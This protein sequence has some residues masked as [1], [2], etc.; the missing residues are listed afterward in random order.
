MAHAYSSVDLRDAASKV[1]AEYS[2]RHK[3][4]KTA[5][6]RNLQPANRETFNIQGHEESI[7][8]DEG[9]PV[10]HKESSLTV[11]YGGPTL[12]QDVVLINE[13]A[14]F[15]RERIP[16]RVVHAKGAAAT[17]YFLVDHDITKYSAACVFEPGKTTQVAVR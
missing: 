3:V 1:L 6:T 5:M 13:L 9:A 7:T 17:G 16:E 2:S 11:G 4:K 12:L 10:G 8:S 15:S 14:H